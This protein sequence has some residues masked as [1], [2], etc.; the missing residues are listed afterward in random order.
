M[1]LK[2]IVNEVDSVDVMVALSKSYKD[3]E[4]N[5]TGY[6]RVL[7]ELKGLEPTSVLEGW[8]VIIQYIEPTEDINGY[9]SVS[10]VNPDEDMLYAME[11]EPWG[12]WLALKVYDNAFDD[13]TKAEFMAHVLWEM[14]W[15]GFSQERVKARR[16]EI[17]SY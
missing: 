9:Y 16:E 5:I 3:Q 7:E 6:K 15:A 2:D 17:L 1:I 10:G 13:M 8:Y 4:K 14:T 11:Y 12:N